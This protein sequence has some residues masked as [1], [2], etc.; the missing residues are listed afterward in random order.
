MPFASHHSSAMVHYL[1]SC[2]REPTSVAS[3]GKVLAREDAKV[4][5]G[6]LVSPCLW[7]LR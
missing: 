6:F 1:F 3:K 7:I 4:R 2:S 5:R